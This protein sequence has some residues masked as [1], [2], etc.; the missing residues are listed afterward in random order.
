MII[1][2]WHT[3][4][5]YCHWPDSST[6]P[7]PPPTTSWSS[8]PSSEVTS[9]SGWFAQ[10][11]G[12]PSWEQPVGRSRSRSFFSSAS[13]GPLFSLT[14]LIHLG[15]TCSF[16]TCGHLD[17]FGLSPSFPSF[18][19]L[20]TFC[21]HHQS[22][23]SLSWVHVSLYLLLLLFLIFW[24]YFLLS[25]SF[26]LPPPLT[27]FSLSLNFLFSFSLS[28]YF[29]ATKKSRSINTFIRTFDHQR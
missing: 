2:I 10:P 8:S 25:L 16:E 19:L 23:N 26:S 28:Q 17:F 4:H 11:L 24:S 7:S 9:S 22:S 13:L 5:C 21:C 3:C 1:K 18:S 15:L 6:L 12:C 14:L 20:F 29:P 27:V